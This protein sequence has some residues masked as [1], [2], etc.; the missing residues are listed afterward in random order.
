VVTRRGRKTATTSVPSV[1]TRVR[2]ISLSLPETSERLSHGQPTFFIRGKR[3]FVMFL[4]NHHGD[5]RL[6]LWCA[7]SAE[8]QRMLVKVGPEHYFVPPYVGYLGWIGV[9]LDRNLG[10]ERIAEA[11]EDA[12]LTVAPKKLIEAA[13]MGAG[14]D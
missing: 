1:L 9:R 10:W 14:N 12:Y 13:K 6:A 4:N 3:A 8:I 7:S 5:G 11:I 2:R